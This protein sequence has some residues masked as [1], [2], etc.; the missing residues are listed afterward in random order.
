MEDLLKVQDLKIY[1]AIGSGLLRQPK[2]YVRAVDGVSLSLRPGEILALVGE[3]GCGKTTIARAIMGLVPPTAGTITFK[4]KTIN[5]LSDKDLQD[6]RRLVQMVFQDPFD[7]L[8]PRKTIFQTL[9]QPLRIH[10]VT[11]RS[12]LRQEATHL[13]ELVGLTPVS[14][15]LDRYPHQFSGGQRQRICMARAIALRPNLIVADEPVSSLDISIRAQILNLMR[16]LQREFHLAYIFIS[17]DLGVVR[18]FCDRVAVMYLGKLVE[19][20]DT[21]VIFSLPRHPYTRALLAASPIPDP[22][23]ARQ[24]NR[25]VLSGDTPSPV[26]PP[27]GCYFHPRCPIAQPICQTLPPAYMIFDEKH[28]SACH[29]A[30]R[31]EPWQEKPWQEKPWQEE[32]IPS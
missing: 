3:S 24:R 32:E 4:G 15:Y 6:Y 20:G 10:H 21:E 11:P 23:L 16:D 12:A 17:H 9:A 30:D 31:L 2:G 8:N 13:L 18:S 28:F 26:H 27:S 29:F 7:S 25:V 14:A 22:V 5:Q 1:Y 19:E